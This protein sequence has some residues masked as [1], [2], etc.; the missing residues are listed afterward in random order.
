LSGQT[1]EIA[2][3]IYIDTNGYVGYES[4]NKS[5][6]KSYFIIIPVFNGSAHI[7]KLLNG[8]K[9]NQEKIIIID[10]CSTEEGL[11]EYLNSWAKKNGGQYHRNDTNMGY[12]KSVNA[13][14]KKSNRDFI[15]LNSDTEVFGDWAERLIHR[16]HSDEKIA[17]VTPFSNS[18][19]IYSFPLQNQD[20][21]VE[22]EIE[23]L[24]L[25]SEVNTFFPSPNAPTANGFCMAIKRDAWEKI[26]EFDEVKFS[27]G[28]GEECDWS[29]RAKKM[30][31]KVVLAPDVFVKHLQGGSFDPITKKILLKQS[32][33]TLRIEWPQ[34]FVQVENH[35]NM[36]PWTNFR[37]RIRLKLLLGNNWVIVFKTNLPG[38]AHN[39]F[40]NKINQFKSNGKSVLEVYQNEYGQIIGVPHGTWSYENEH[41]CKFEFKDWVELRSFQKSFSSIN[42]VVFSSLV[43]YLS[44]LEVVK[45][46]GK[47]SGNFAELPG[48][49]FFSLCPSH[50]LLNDKDI[51]CGLPSDLSICRTCLPKNHNANLNYRNVN[52]F[53]WRQ[54]WFKNMNSIQYFSKST[55]NIFNLS[56]IAHVDQSLNLHNEFSI[57]QKNL[58]KEVFVKRQNLMRL[59]LK[60]KESLNIAFVGAF[61]VNKGSKVFLEIEGIARRM[62]KDWKFHIFGRLYGHPPRQ[63]SHYDYGGVEQLYDLLEEH[64][65][66]LCIIPTIWPETYNY[67]LDELQLFGFCVIVSPLG[68]LAERISIDGVSFG[69]VAS[70]TSGK[71][72]FDAIQTYLLEMSNVD[73]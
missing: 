28:Y 26:G 17:S 58:A 71:E 73:E 18:A 55:E 35:I 30:K 67:V 6:L 19:T 22:Q 39:W 21:L 63:I 24:Q 1:F 66:D 52:I 34:Y 53:D 49:D 64:Q 31:W 12:I 33:K 44:P 4:E 54:A 57:S 68:A 45:I 20:N 56:K 70:G 16:L 2:T 42:E 61:S 51:F 32:E 69:A 3:K 29:M 50:N 59:K 14:I 15:L 10:D 27:L 41:L 5:T 13:V 48:H 46:F 37:A 47:E 23:E 72:F 7:K 60:R 8:I 43:G 38:G 11:S 40:L 62:N 36:D 9:E 25:A 65:I